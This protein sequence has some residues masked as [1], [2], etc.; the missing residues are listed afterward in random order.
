MLLSQKLSSHLQAHASSESLID[1]QETSKADR[2]VTNHRD[3]VTA[4]HNRYPAPVAEFPS[5]QAPAL[6]EELFMWYSARVVIIPHGAI[7][8]LFPLEPC[9]GSV[10][11]ESNGFGNLGFR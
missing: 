3:L 9:R 8:F 10:S 11:L 6:A 5:D 2:C 4:L 7:L 1:G